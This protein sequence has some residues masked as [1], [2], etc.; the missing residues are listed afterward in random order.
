MFSIMIRHPGLEPGS[1]A[2]LGASANV[3]P[4]SRPG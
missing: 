2:G 4:G 1:M 3:D